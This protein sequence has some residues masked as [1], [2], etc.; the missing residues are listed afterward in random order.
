[1]NKEWSVIKLKKARVPDDSEEPQS[2]KTKKDE[3]TQKKEPL[4]E[5]DLRRLFSKCADIHFQTMAFGETAESGVDVVLISCEGM[6]DK[7]LLNQ[8]VYLKLET[9]FKNNDP[10]AMTSD[11]VLQSLHLPELKEAVDENQVT[12]DV[13]SGKLLLYFRNNGYLFSADIARRPQRTP[14]ETKTEISVQGPKDDFIEDL[15]INIALV[16]KRLRTASLKVEKFEVGK[17]SRTSVALLF[18]DDIASKPIVDEL[19]RCLRTITIDAIYNGNQLMELFE[20]NPLMAPKHSYTGRPDFAVKALVSGRCV[21]FIDGVAYAN[22]VP[23]NI[24]FLL[25]TSEDDEYSA[26]YSSF[27]RVMRVVGTLIAVFL[28]S[29]WVAITTFH[30]NQLPMSLLAPIVESR[31]GLPLPT[32]LEAILMLMMFELFKEAGLR[33]PAAIGSTLS[34]VG[35]LI[36]GEAAIEAKLTSPAMLVVVAISTI[37]TFTFVNQS[38]VGAVSL[39]RILAIIIS[40]F[41]GLFGDIFCFLSITA[42]VSNIKVFGFPYVEMLANLDPVNIMKAVFRPPAT[43]NPARPVM[44]FSKDNTPKKR[45]QK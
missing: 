14:E 45:R 5:S 11:W 12:A 8:S 20:K 4:S 26:I 22:I 6:I 43:F 2:K 21:I 42:Y 44:M 9:L 3:R 33:M 32:S 24:F 15:A 35:A 31:R 13:F 18:I 27:E 30:Q 28:P 25:K 36:M 39:L 34:V 40:S 29:F 16:R 23:A 7:E 41:F 37:A 38:L 19:R 17:R 10:A 1:M